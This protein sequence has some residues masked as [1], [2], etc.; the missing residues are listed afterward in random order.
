MKIKNAK[1]IFMIF[2][3]ACFTGAGIPLIVNTA[4]NGQITWA[5][6]PL[7]SL[8]FV[9]IVSSLLLVK[10]HGTLLFASALTVLLLPYLYFLSRITPVTDWFV[11]VGLPSAIAGIII[12]WIILL[13]FR[14]AKINTLCKAAISVF[15]L[16]AVHSPL[17]NYFIDTYL[18]QEPFAWFRFL[19]IFV[20]VVVSA[21]LGIAGYARAKN[22]RCSND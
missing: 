5:A 4:I 12:A 2:T 7:I 9:W 14:F 11:P 6:Y 3:L 16:G 18:E 21:A 19:N 15:L 13:L 1:I 8:A 20:C 17:V 22:M 10:K